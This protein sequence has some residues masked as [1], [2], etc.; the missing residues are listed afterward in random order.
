MFSMT[1]YNVADMNSCYIK[2]CDSL[3]HV[4]MRMRDIDE[5][6]FGLQIRKKEQK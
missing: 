5:E 3:F 6:K 1:D 4:E 2:K